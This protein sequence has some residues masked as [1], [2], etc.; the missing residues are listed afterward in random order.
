LEQISEHLINLFYTE[1]GNKL[2]Q[3]KEDI[4][5]DSRDWAEEISARS[6]SISNRREIVK[7]T[8]SKL[9][10]LYGGNFDLSSSPNPGD[11][12]V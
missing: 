5:V 2:T 3:F 12:E 6:P 9:L 1:Y 7:L 4:L 11:A 10:Q 8:C